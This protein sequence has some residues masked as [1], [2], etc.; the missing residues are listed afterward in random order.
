MV[1]LD[2]TPLRLTWPPLAPLVGTL[3]TWTPLALAVIMMIVLVLLWL[4]MRRH[5]RIARSDAPDDSVDAGTVIA[6]REGGDDPGA[7]GASAG[8]ER[9]PQA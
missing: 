5:I 3:P 4:S 8:D 1:L 6:H 2:L 9:A 7:P